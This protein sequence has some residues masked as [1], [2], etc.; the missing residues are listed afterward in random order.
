MAF[1]IRQLVI[2]IASA[3][4]MA[5]VGISVIGAAVA[6]APATERAR[7]SAADAG[8]PDARF[9]GRLS[10]HQQLRRIFIDET[11]ERLR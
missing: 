2:G 1:R 7:A 5:V 10:E 8:R 6:L 9:A 4:T 3:V 11:R